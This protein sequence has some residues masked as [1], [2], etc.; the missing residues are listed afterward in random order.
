MAKTFT[1][2]S[3]EMGILLLEKDVLDDTP[4]LHVNQGYKYLDA[5]G[6]A[7]TQLDKSMVSFSIAIVD[8]PVSIKSALQT[9]IGFMETKA[10]EKE[11]MVQT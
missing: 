9:I 1:C 7:I 4:I 2:E 6:E 3:L 5:D 11:G 10:Y 8:I